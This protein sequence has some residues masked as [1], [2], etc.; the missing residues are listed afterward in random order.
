M[1]RTSLRVRL[2]TLHAL[3]IQSRLSVQR[4]MRAGNERRISQE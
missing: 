1:W 3:A 2:S 4:I